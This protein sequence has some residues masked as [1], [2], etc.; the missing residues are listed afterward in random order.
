M[1]AYLLY[2]GR[3]RQAVRALAVA[4]ASVGVATTQPDPGLSGHGLV[5]LICLAAAV[6]T[7]ALLVTERPH[8]AAL[9]RC[10][11][12]AVASALLVGYA[13]S[14]GSVVLLV[15]AGLDAGGSLPFTQ[16][17]LVA[18]LALAVDAL[19]TLASSHTPGYSGLGSA[20]IFGFLAAT[21]IRQ[22][23]LRAEEA[24]LRLA[25]AER[26][27]EEHARAAG[28]A[29]RANVARE[30]HD[31]LAHSLGALVLQLDAVDALLAEDTGEERRARE[32]LGR[33]RNLAIDGLTEARRA[34]GSLR[35]DPPP[36]IESLQ[37]LLDHSD[38]ADLRV[39]GTPRPTSG[40]VAVTLRRTAQ[41]SLTNAAKHAPGA[42]PSVD[43]EFAPNALVLTVA[44]AGS[45]DGTAPAPHADSGGGYG[46][47][48]LRERATLIGGT[49]TA[50]PH[51]NGWRVQLTIP[52]RLHD[53][54]GART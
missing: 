37:Q 44:D 17:A 1:N 53:A 36:L 10:I 23:T 24:E 28:L 38:L 30:I 45:P 31:I 3:Y 51:G 12:G 14:T 5:V 25:D 13:P 19:G 8:R 26:A 42:R 33:A 41:E 18:V 4:A 15:F 40:E 16:G 43:L 34:V 21:T 48:G 39:T 32:L 6:G 29:E 2:S 52:Q 49:L 46:I 11:V 20:V 50:G 9:A 27:R 35:Q 7:Q 54:D 47:D 22:Y